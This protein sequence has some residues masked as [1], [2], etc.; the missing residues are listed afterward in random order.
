[1]VYLLF[2]K[3]QAH[4]IH[5]TQ[6]RKQRTLPAG[7]N[8]NVALIAKLDLKLK[9]AL[10]QDLVVRVSTHRQYDRLHQMC[11]LK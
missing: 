4:Q 8:L 9:V 5:Q 2:A 11:S 10:H 6:D 3:R 1:M 7:L